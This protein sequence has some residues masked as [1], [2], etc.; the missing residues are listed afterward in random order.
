MNA[1][2]QSESLRIALVGAGKMARQHARAIAAP[3]LHARLAAVADASASALEGIRPLAPEA[4]LVGSLTEALATGPVD[5]VHICTPPDTHEALATEAL[6]A[7]CHV[8]V[9][10]PIAPSEAATRHLLDLAA[11]RRLQLCPGHQLLFEP[12]A[13]EIRRLLPAVGRVIHVESYFSFRTVRRT[14]DGKAPLRADL[15]LLD[16]LP[17]PVYLLLDLLERAAPG[18]SR[19]V[20]LELGRSGSL[21]ALVRRGEVTGALVVS[22]EARPVESYLRVTGTNGALLGDFVRGTVER[23]I[24]PGTSGIDKVLAPYRTAAQLLSGTTGALARRAL[25]RQRSYPG[26]VEI[27]DSFYA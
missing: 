6:E 15:Q 20:A 19:L 24:V 18:D 9:E 11:A 8:Y 1:A 25:G 27:F 3:T 26:L 2:P 5:V 21:H 4:R 23:L 16:I 7:G 13:R 14:P 10:K 12:P 17:H 22:V